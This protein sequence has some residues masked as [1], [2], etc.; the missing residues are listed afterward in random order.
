MN[1]VVN[2]SVDRIR[3]AIYHNIARTDPETGDSDRR[4]RC[5]L[6]YA[7]FVCKRHIEMSPSAIDRKFR[8]T[9]PFR[10]ECARHLSGKKRQFAG[11]IRNWPENRP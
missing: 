10:G 8:P 7:A 6:S 2:G 3:Q 4:F 1:G 11:N 5:D 9:A